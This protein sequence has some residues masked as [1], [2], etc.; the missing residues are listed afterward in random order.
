MVKQQRNSKQ[1]GSSPGNAI[2][3][4]PFS[5]LLQG[6][7]QQGKYRQALDEIKRGRRNNPD[8]K[9]TP[10]EAEIWS[11]R[12]QQE[13]DKGEI[14]Q[15]ETSFRRA[16]EQGLVGEAHYWIG[17][18]LLA[19]NK[20]DAAL[21]LVRESFE[22]GQ[23]PKEYAIGYL[24]LLLL[25]ED[26]ATVEHLISKQSKR[27]SA[28]QLH[29][30]RGV[31]ALKAGQPQ[32]A[33]AS[34]QKI[35]RPIT[36]D[37]C[38]DAWLAYTYQQMEDWDKAG[39][40]LGLYPSSPWGFSL[41]GPK[42]LQEPILTRLAMAQRAKTGKPALTL[43]D[44][45]QSN[46]TLQQALVA[47]AALQLIDT[48]DYHNTAHLLLDP[49]NFSPWP[50]IKALRPGILTLAGEQAMQGG[51]PQ[52]TE[53]FWKPLLTEQ[54]FNPQLAVNLLKALQLNESYKEEQRL[55]TRL[56][57]WVEQDSKKHPELWGGDR[58][59]LTLS[60]LHCILADSWISLDRGRAALGSVQQAERICPTSPEVLGRKGIIAAS[61]EKNEEAIQLLTQALEQG[62]QSENVYNLLLELWDTLDNPQAKLDARRRFGK[63]FGDLNAEQEVNFEPWLDALY[64]QNYAFFSR[65]VETKENPNPPLRACQIFVESVQGMP[66]GSGRISLNQDRAIQQWEALLK[67]LPVEQQIPTIQAIALALH[68]FAKREK[69]IAAL[70]TRY[71]VRLAELGPTYT[72]A[73]EAHLVLLATKESNY[74]KLEVP[75]RSYLSKMPQPASALAQ[76]Q[77]QVRRFGSSRNLLRLIQ[78]FLE[79]EPQNPL[80]LLAK[81]TTYP[82]SSREY[83][84]LKQ[85]GFDVA[86]R[87]QDAKALQAF[88]EEDAFVNLREAQAILPHPDAFDTMDE[89]DMLD[90]MEAMVRRMFGGQIPKAELDRMMP[91]LKR[92][93]LN[94]MP[95][96]DDDD[97]FFDDDDDIDIF[98]IFGKPKKRKTFRNL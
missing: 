74:Q 75:L 88:R 50:E 58:L 44:L 24:K 81:A 79:Q 59:P 89:G 96:F 78:E 4:D 3:P 73:R 52:C 85:Q 49:K 84:E 94:D 43:N 11:L 23:L 47:L 39:Q 22:Q 97:N 60:H 7:L 6:L 93:M 53:V 20:L 77:L 51:E 14:K 70:I 98:P 82:L 37:D 92:K 21:A 12:G 32:D 27:F 45:N 95:I 61:E 16:L 5:V 36:P 67:T 72:E 55:V 66:T 86:R 76:V 19:Q 31:L 40:Q 57:K 68:L 15:A 38:P 83:E 80:L 54:P 42:Y 18:C 71:M 10:S 17:R 9:F 63:A 65:L 30:T 48:E 33:L 62:C 56:I 64:T 26:V 46:P 29:W 25:K 34:F 87:I 91:E 1:A 8:L 2:A 35:K 41:L 13:F 69:G 90:I 28:A